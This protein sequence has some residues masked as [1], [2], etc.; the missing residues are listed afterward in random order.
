[1][2]GESQSGDHPQNSQFGNATM[3]NAKNVKSVKSVKSNAKNAVNP[4]SVHRFTIIDRP[5]VL[6]SIFTPYAS[7]RGIVGFAIDG[8]TLSITVDSRLPSPQS[9]TDFTNR[10]VDRNAV[11]FA[12]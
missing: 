4:V 7:N 2:S 6:R 10:L 12:E 5:A 3:S 8:D 9:F 11:S 1:M